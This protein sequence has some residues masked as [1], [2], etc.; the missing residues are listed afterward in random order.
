MDKTRRTGISRQTRPR[1]GSIAPLWRRTPLWV[2][3]LS[4]GFLAGVGIALGV[5]LSLPPGTGSNLTTTQAEVGQ[6]A[7]G[8]SLQN[9]GG[10]TYSLTPGD[11]ENHLL[12]FYMGYF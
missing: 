3:L 9:S 12:V 6:P 2:Y 5:V 10:E 8:F 7:P 4:F 11:G 1:A